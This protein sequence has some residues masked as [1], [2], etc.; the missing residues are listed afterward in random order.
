MN[1]I[2]GDVLVLGAGMAGLT[3]ARTLA[4]RGFRVRVLEA[5]DRVGGRI[6][7]QRVEGGGVVELGAEFVHGRPPELWALIHEA[8]VQVVQRDG[9]MLYEG[10]DGD[11]IEDERHDES[12]FA[13]LQDLEKFKGEDRTFADWLATRK[14]IDHDERATLTGYVEGFNAADARRISARSL[15]AQQAAED[16]N[17]GG[18]SWHLTGGYAQLPEYLAGRLYELGV[19]IHLHCTVRALRWRQGE[20]S[21]ETARGEFSARQCIVTLPLGVLQQVNGPGG[22]RMEPEARAIAAARR[23]EMGHASRFTMVFRE[24]WWERSKALAV[25]KLRSMSFLFTPERMPPVWWSTRPETE[26]LPTLTGWAGGPRAAALEGKSAEELGRSA[27]ETL[28]EVFGVDQQIIR[29]A[30]VDTYTHDWAA[31][32][33]FCGAYSYI[34]VGAT[35]APHGMSQIESGTI[36]FAGEHTDVTANWGT[37]HAAIRSGLRAAEQTIEE[38]ATSTGRFA[39]H[40]VS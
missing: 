25:K 13:P 5:T 19:E 16:E 3:A 4:E 37:V 8:G 17:E 10:W 29:S 33:C 21:V 32:S 12:L 38:V 34:P 22:I 9:V 2:L 23:L 31:D 11:L 1:R 40:A 7:S 39:K 18:R 24:R 30:L 27:C 36:L 20:V 28:A 6:H 35:D 15:G 26:A 14:E